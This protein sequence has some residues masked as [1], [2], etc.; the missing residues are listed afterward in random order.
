MD[1]ERIWIDPIPPELPEKG[2]I[3]WCLGK[4]RVWEGG[5]VPPFA[6]EL[7]RGRRRGRTMKIQISKEA[8]PVVE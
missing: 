3:W 5:W 1:E 6:P 7:K 2:D 4:R 8:E